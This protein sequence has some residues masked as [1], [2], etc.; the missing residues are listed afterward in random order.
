MLCNFSALFFSW[1]NTSGLHSSQGLSPALLVIWGQKTLSTAGGAVVQLLCLGGKGEGCSQ[2]LSVSQIGCLVG[3]VLELP[4]VLRELTPL[5]LYLVL[6]LLWGQSALAACLSA[7]A[8][9]GHTVSTPQIVTRPSGQM[10]LEG[11]LRSGWGCD[12]ASCLG[13]GKLG[14]RTSKTPG[15]RI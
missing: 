1:L 15:L 10:G 4:S 5:P 9:P 14:S 13:V 6:A 7:R 3:S 12:S 8:P 2:L 11:T